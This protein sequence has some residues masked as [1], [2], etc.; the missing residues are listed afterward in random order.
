LT[1][2]ERVWIADHPV[3][4]VGIEEW[5]PFVRAEKDGT[6]GGIAGDFLKLV[7]E[8]TGLNIKVVRGE[9]STLLKDFE[10]GKIDLLPATYYTDERATYGLYSNPYFSAKEFLY[11]KQRNSSI[12]SFDDLEGKQLAIVEGYGTIPKI[13]EKFP[14][15]EIVETKNQFASI[16]A[17]LNGDVDALFESQIVVDDL[18]RRELIA[19]LKAVGQT[20]FEASSLYYFSRI[21]E[22]L[23]PSI[24]T[25]SLDSIIEEERRKLINKWVVQRGASTVASDP[26]SE[27][28]GTTW[29]FVGAVFVFV[30]LLFTAL[31]LPRFITGEKLVDQFGSTRFRIIALVA[32]SLMVVLVAGLVWRALDQNKNIAL[33][34]TRENLDVVLKNTMER[35]DLWVSERQ[36]FLMRLGRDPELVKITKKLLALPID[37]DALKTS[38]P[39]K[40]IRKFFKENEDEFGKIGFFIINPNAISIGSGRDSN[41]GTTNLI[42]EQKPE[43]LAKAFQGE[44]VFIPPIRSDVIIGEQSGTSSFETHKPLTMFFAVPIRDLDGTVLAVLTQRLLPEGQMSKIMQGGRTGQS[45]ESYL[46]NMEGVLVTESRFKGQLIDIGLLNSEGVNTEGIQV[47]DPGGD[48]LKGYKPKTPMS[49]RPLTRMAESVLK[50]GQNSPQVGNDKGHTKRIIDVTDGYR[51]YRGVPVFGAWVWDTHLGLG[52]TSEID[53]EEALAGYY[54]LRLSLLLITVIPLVFTLFGLLVTLIIGERSTHVMRRALAGLET[55]VQV[56]TSEVAETDQLL[57]LA[58]D[59]IHDGFVFY[60]SDSRLLFCH[61]QYRLLFLISNDL[62]IP[63]AW[64]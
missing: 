30:A 59:N 42:A 2:E 45:G 61:T 38:E 29:F 43:L 48:M 64:F 10:N 55:R 35:L 52:M 25:K 49:E 58:I 26:A 34:T 31:L 32:T 14:G 4:S 24:L 23:L 21:D 27:E 44:A 16:T 11:V 40:R 62:I 1:E 5:F 28:T 12:R 54:S 33:N 20:S 36:K 47:R 41:L 9:W 15:I 57:R 63:G 56:R 13:R 17:V 60:D 53:V 39:Q 8:K 22:P 37:A 46:V 3:I 7:L 18:V 51:D 6:P 50:M 19:G